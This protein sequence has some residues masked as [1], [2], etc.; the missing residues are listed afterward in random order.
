[1]KSYLD[2]LRLIRETGTSKH[3][4]RAESGKTKNPTIGLPNLHFSHDLSEGFPL[5]TTRKI[6]W[7]P[8]VG[9]L[10]A[11]LQGATTNKEFKAN[12]CNFWTP[13]AR[14]DGSLGPIYGKQWNNHGQ[15]RH[16]IIFRHVEANS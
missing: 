2:M 11:F 8:L 15:L 7:K 9:E 4:S 12:D 1:M 13:W 5:L 6:A 10:R 3:P 16:E 14:E